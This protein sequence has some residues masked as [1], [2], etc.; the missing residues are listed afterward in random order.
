MDE[1]RTLARVMKNRQS[2]QAS[3]ERKRRY[4][5][6]LEMHRAHL[7]TE[8]KL[9]RE[10]VSA[11]EDDKRLLMAEI[12][13]LRADM[14]RL[15]SPSRPSSVSSLSSPSSSSSA[16]SHPSFPPASSTCSSMLF[17]SLVDQSAYYSESHIAACRP[18]AHE[19]SL[20][21]ALCRHVV[22]SS[23]HQETSDGCQ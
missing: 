4:M 19:L 7:L 14:T 17:E 20:A 8:S 13:Q 12:R 11:L 21:E 3:R 10:R 15:Q 6:D 9:L 2:A 22:R 23:S 16:S 18:S 5:R 1:L